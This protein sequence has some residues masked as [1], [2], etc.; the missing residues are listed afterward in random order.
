MPKR[1]VN[2]KSSKKQCPE[3]KV[4]N[5]KTGRCI[6][7]SPSKKASIRQTSK[8]VSRKV[9]KKVSRKPVKKSPRKVSKKASRKVVRKSPRKVSKKVSRKVSKKE[10]PEGKVLNPKTGRC[11]KKSPVKKSVRK[12][13]KKVLRKGS[14]KVSRKVSKKECPEGKVLNPKTGRCIK[15]SLSKKSVRK[16]SKKVLRKASKKSLRKDVSRKVAKTSKKVSKEKGVD[17]LKALPIE[18]MRKIL[19]QVHPDKSINTKSYNYIIE[20]LSDLY[21]KAQKD[22]NSGNIDKF[23][24]RLS[25]ELKKHAGAM[26]KRAAMDVENKVSLD[27]Y[28]IGPIWDAKFPG[29]KSYNYRYGTVFEYLLAEILELSG[30]VN[31]ESDSITEDDIKKAIKNDEELKKLLMKDLIEEDVED[32]PGFNFRKIS[33]DEFNTFLAVDEDMPP[34]QLLSEDAYD[35]LVEHLNNLYKKLKDKDDKEI[36]ET[37]KKSVY[38]DYKQKYALEAIENYI[39]TGKP[40]I[41]FNYDISELKNMKPIL[42]YLFNHII[43]GIFNSLDNDINK[44]DDPEELPDPYFVDEDRMEEKIERYS[45]IDF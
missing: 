24:E 39:N 19:K 23:L 18:S 40:L 15:K 25:G 28:I 4:L 29:Q 6:K 36:L 27:K 30:S 31:L 43:D 5:P 33:I 3:G 8:K 1:S 42:R 10:C 37:L 41:G 20:L 9:A 22:Y 45:F 32:E 14:K 17:I 26:Q 34:T 16:V 38:V 11:I 7:K 21:T 12:A 13:S 2:K 35:M 44:M